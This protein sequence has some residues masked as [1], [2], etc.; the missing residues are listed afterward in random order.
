MTPEDLRGLDAA[1]RE[2][3]VRRWRDGAEES[4]TDA[5]AEECPVAVVFN[6]EPFAVMLASPMDLE[7]FA[8]GFTW[9]EGIVEDPSEFQG[10]EVVPE[11]EG[12]SVYVSVP[13]ARTE[14][15]A[16]RRRSLAGRTGCGLCGTQM[17]D[18]AIRP[19]RA[20]RPT[21]FDPDAVQRAQ[22]ELVAGQ[23]LNAI[24]GAVHAAGWADATGR[25]QLVR[26]DVGRHNA[27]D[28]LIGALLAAGI[29]PSEGFVVVTSRASYEMVHKTAAAGVPLLAAVSAPTA[30][31]IR[32]AQS[33][34]LTLVGFTRDRR[35]T[36]YAGPAS[37]A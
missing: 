12:F 8:R 13:K 18:E 5:V 27:L 22:A 1:Y 25:I 28:K 11:D 14:S 30:L 7:D 9:S 32:I 34:G 17:L 26:E 2:V 33:A 3:P 37:P 31:A 35:H 10:V 20:V 29:D 23:S 6:G 15:L 19:V 4:G 24:T 36:V 16:A 21:S